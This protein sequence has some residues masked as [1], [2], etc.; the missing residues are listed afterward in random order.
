MAGRSNLAVANFDA[1]FDNGFSLHA[2]MPNPTARDLV[3]AKLFAVFS[4]EELERTAQLFTIRT[5][6]KGAILVSEGDR[7]EFFSIILAGRVKFFWRDER[8]RQVDVATVGP[9]EDFAAQAL[10]REPMLNTVIALEP[11]RLAT[12]PL[13]DFERLLLEH[14]RLALAYVKRVVGLFRRATAGRR[15]MAM[16][17]VY[18]RVTELLLTSAV[19]LDG[20]RVTE[21]L[22]HAEIGQRVGATREMVGRILRELTKG[23]YIEPEGGRFTVRRTPPRHW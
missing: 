4:P 19:E 14:P 17:D 6:P 18:G 3:G 5:Y 23:G 20:K 8:G 21:K 22:T 16:E 15:S 2:D 12:L 10:G 13:A 7:L 1:R 11:L 9:D